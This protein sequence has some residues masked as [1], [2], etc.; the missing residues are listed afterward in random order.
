MKHLKND[1]LCLIFSEKRNCSLLAPKMQVKTGKRE[2]DSL[3]FEKE[4]DGNQTK[5][6]YREKSETEKTNFR[7]LPIFRIFAFPPLFVFRNAILKGSLVSFNHVFLKAS[8][9]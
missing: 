2:T 3:F 7:T 1:A 8:T 9:I 5:K 4:D 6:R